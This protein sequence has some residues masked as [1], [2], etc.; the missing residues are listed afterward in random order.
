MTSVVLSLILPTLAAPAERPHLPFHGVAAEDGAH[1]YWVNPALM[2]F[3]RDASWGLYYDRGAGD[4]TEDV[5]LVS[6]AGGFGT[7]VAHRSVGEPRN[8]QNTD[9]TEGRNQHG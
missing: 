2:N 3:D 8:C 4:V 9:H 6:T 1:T 7:T 5:A